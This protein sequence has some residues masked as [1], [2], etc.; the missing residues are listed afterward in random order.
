MSQFGARSDP[1]IGTLAWGEGNR[2]DHCSKWGWLGA[3][4][5]W[6]CSPARVLR[7]QD[8]PKAIFWDPVA[9]ATAPASLISAT[10]LEVFFFALMGLGS[11][12]GSNALVAPSRAQAMSGDVTRLLFNN[13]PAKRVET[14]LLPMDI[15]DVAAISDG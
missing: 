1:A 14:M 6:Q 9:L 4:H 3:S 7:S 8:G 2:S 15:P 11:A 10:G 13:R 5:E 12:A